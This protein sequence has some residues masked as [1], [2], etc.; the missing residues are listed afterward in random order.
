MV[1]TKEDIKYLKKRIE[2]TK[3]LAANHLDK[4]SDAKNVVSLDKLNVKFERRNDRPVRL[5]RAA[6]NN[7]N[8][9]SIKVNQI[10]E[11][12]DNQSDSSGSSNGSSS[13]K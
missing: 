3:L 1:E 4:V 9:R 2:E 10:G 7:K 8:S 12:S 11:S 6:D 5:G 13:E